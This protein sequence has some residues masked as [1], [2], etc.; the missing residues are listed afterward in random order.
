MSLVEFVM[1]CVRRRRIFSASSSEFV[2][3]IPPSV[4]IILRDETKDSDVAVPTRANWAT[5]IRRS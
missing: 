1:P 4:A 2:K 3:L 5:F